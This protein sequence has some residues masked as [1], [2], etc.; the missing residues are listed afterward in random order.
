[1]LGGKE[2]KER[3]SDK[4]ETFLM[5]NQLS[6]NRHLQYIIDVENGSNRNQL[7]CRAPSKAEENCKRQHRS[8]NMN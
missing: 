3:A 5:K 2:V 4:V 1:M 6:S 7:T 8:Q